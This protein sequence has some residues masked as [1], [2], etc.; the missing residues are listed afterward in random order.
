MRLFWDEVRD[1]ASS[2][3]I[4]LYLSYFIISAAFAVAQDGELQA[5]IRA[6]K[7][8]PVPERRLKGLLV[9][10]RT[11]TVEEKAS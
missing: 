10:A 8:K 5:I 1:E 4:T 9:S 7:M 11:N 3:F 2:S 6:A